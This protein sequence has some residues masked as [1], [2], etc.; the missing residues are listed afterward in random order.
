MKALDL[1]DHLKKYIVDDENIEYTSVEHATWRFILRLLKNYLSKNAHKSYLK[2]LES[3]GITTEEIPRI[4]DISEKLSQ[5][6]WRAVPVSGFIPPAV[7]MELQS[8]SL[9][10]IASDMRT[11]KHL[12]Y[13]PAPDIIHE[14]AGHAPLLVNPSFSNYLKQYA[15]I[16][17]KAIM[18]KTDLD[19]YKA[20]R[21]LSDIKEYSEST[22]EDNERAEKNLDIA[23]KNSQGVSEAAI[24]ARMNWWTAEYGL[25]GDMNNPKIYGAGL[26]SSVG[27][28]RTALEDITKKIPFSKDCVN[29]S[30][31]ITEPQP[32]LFVTSSFDELTKVLHEV[33]ETMAF[34]RGGEESL[35]KAIIAKTINTVQL[36]SNLQISGLLS[37]IRKNDE[38]KAI[39]LHF[40]GPCQLSYK[41]V[42]LTHHGTNRHSEGF[43]AP[44][45]YLEREEVCLS[46]M[47][48]SE[49]ESLNFIENH[50]I[51]L[52]YGSGIR[53]CGTVKSL[54]FID[55]KPLLATL[56]D[57]KVTFA[58]E[59]LF[60]PE[61]GEYDLVF[62]SSV[63]SVFRG[64]ADRNAYGM[65]EEDFEAKRVPQ[66]HYTETE[67][68]LMNLYQD[69]REQRRNH[70]YNIKKV[71]SILNDLKKNHANDW[72]LKLEIYEFCLE[73]DPQPQWTSSLRSELLEHNVDDPEVKRLIETGLQLLEKHG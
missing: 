43:G 62:G 40:E 42:Q 63:P 22:P 25:I 18:Y 37:Y 12:A 19:I 3:T 27:E 13:T 44:L 48:L 68:H 8:L 66:K 45:G 49:L 15:E 53:I 71:E 17:S 2:G 59:V 28:S 7:F 51:D 46:E 6:G 50:R 52:K 20:I 55:N 29:F 30:Y 67:N 4:K 9:L 24:L 39:Y 61:W 16:A 70:Q 34:K 23:I 5:F 57:C 33:A 41:G 36:N 47:T 65:I 14:A 1:P 32:Q 21:E 38:G 73:C 35:E 69:V 26:L 60:A 64:P 72:L 58:D 56:K 10:P 11:L 54:D 31:D